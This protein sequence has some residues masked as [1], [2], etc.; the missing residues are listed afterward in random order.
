MVDKIDCSLQGTEIATLL[1][2]DRNEDKENPKNFISMLFL[3]LLVL[4]VRSPWQN[5]I[6]WLSQHNLI[7]RLYRPH[8]FA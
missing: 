6:D 8:T 5:Q 4:H 1:L 3:N 7:R 2:A